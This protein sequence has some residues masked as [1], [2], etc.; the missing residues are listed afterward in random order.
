MNEIKYINPFNSNPI[1]IEKSGFFE[2]GQI[3]FKN[4]KGSYRVLISDNNY[5]ENF[6]FQWNKFVKT[7]IDRKENEISK[8]RFFAETKWDK[9]DLT[10][11][12]VLE[13]GSGAG[14]FSQVI[15]NHTNAN[16]YSVDY[17]NAVEANYANNG[18]HEDRFKLF[19]ASIYEMPFVPK[20]FDKVLC[21]GVLQHTPDFKQSIKS[22]VAQVKPGGE[23]VVDFYT[24]K[25]WWTKIHAKY[26]FRPFTKKMSHE[27][28][29][30]K[31][32]ANVG[33]MI[34]LY[35]FLYK[36]KLGVLTRFIPI[37]DIYGT[38]PYKA[39]T[40]EQIKEWCILDTFDMYSPEH[41]HPQ[42]ISTVKKWVEE[43]G[44]KVTF[45]GFEKYDETNAPVV[46]AIKL[47]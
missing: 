45:A 44:L 21:I 19:Q 40:A 12:N 37:V 24:V 13:V 23:L 39:L 4:I 25:G 3:V 10:N 31:I 46:R 41:D 20:Q 42:S 38:L 6:G 43:F 30:K 22:L 17:S 8:I 14:R 1:T 9:E 18:H 33:W 5:T 2:Y 28:L 27:K 11:K 47:N 32:Q 35:Y 34:K 36:I 7:Q 15:L 16:L 26:L 29:L